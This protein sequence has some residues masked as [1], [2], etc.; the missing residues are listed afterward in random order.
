MEGIFFVC[1]YFFFPHR[2]QFGNDWGSEV[3]GRQREKPFHL[4]AKCIGPLGFLTATSKSI[5]WIFSLKDGMQFPT[6]WKIYLSSCYYF[7]ILYSTKPKAYLDIF[8]LFGCCEHMTYAF[9]CVYNFVRMSI[10][11]S[12]LFM[13]IFLAKLISPG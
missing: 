10:S 12:Y 2:T 7:C 3:E 9:L 1:V 6:Y 13:F 8:V 5:E 4:P 11:V